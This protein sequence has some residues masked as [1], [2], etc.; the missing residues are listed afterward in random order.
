MKTQIFGATAAMLLLALCQ[1]TAFA[2]DNLTQQV[3]Q[4]TQ[5]VNQLESGQSQLWAVVHREAGGAVLW[6]FGAFCALWAQ[7]T[8]RNPWL[9]FFMGLLFS[10]ITVIVL[11]FK[12]SEDRVPKSPGI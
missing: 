7:N 11:L 1:Q 2:Q 9:W 3:N 10:V 8:N 12:N 6:L 5:R 4:L